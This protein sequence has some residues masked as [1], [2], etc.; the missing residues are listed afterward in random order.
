M[1]KYFKSRNLSKAVFILVVVAIL[2]I[3][4]FFIAKE[5]NASGTVI[6]PGQMLTVNAHN[7]CRNVTNNHATL[8]IWVP[9]LLSTEWDSFILNRPA[10]AAMTSCCSPNTCAAIG[11]TCG[12]HADGC[13]GTIA[14]GSCSLPGAWGA[15]T[16]ADT[17]ATSGTQSRSISSCVNGSC[18]VGTE[19]QSCVRNTDGISCGATSCTCGGYPMM[20]TNLWYVCS[21]GVCTEQGST[22]QFCE[23]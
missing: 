19:S 18:V 23:F 5:V 7:Q 21:G 22:T 10:H 6:P 9:H 16:S 14:C 17:C 12:L 4:T 8:S 2:V 1:F 15:C 13:G 11:A 3:T 20:C